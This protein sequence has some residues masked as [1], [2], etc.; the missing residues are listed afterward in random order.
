MDGTPPDRL[1]GSHGDEVAVERSGN[2]GDTRRKHFTSNIEPLRSNNPL[3]LLP[4][5]RSTRFP[6]LKEKSFS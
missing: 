1:H 5:E 6:L 3:I 4:W 2:S